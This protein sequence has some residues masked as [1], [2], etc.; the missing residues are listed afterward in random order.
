MNK[1]DAEKQK[2]ILKKTSLAYDL[3]GKKEREIVFTFGAA[4]RQTPGR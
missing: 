2:K 3:L 4:C 1:T